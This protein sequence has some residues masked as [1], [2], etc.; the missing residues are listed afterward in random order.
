MKKSDLIRHFGNQSKTAEALGITK[1]AVSQW[2]EIVPEGIA[3]KA[4]I[5]TGGALRADPALYDH[6]R[7]RAE[8][9]A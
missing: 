1:S 9:A 3:Y 2:P 4:Q 7:R 6:K 5:V 8:I